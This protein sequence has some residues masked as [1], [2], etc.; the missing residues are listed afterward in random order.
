M[1]SRST[2]GYE[3]IDDDLLVRYHAFLFVDSRRER[4]FRLFYNQL[5]R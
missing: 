4:D 2:A 3:P 5:R 1:D